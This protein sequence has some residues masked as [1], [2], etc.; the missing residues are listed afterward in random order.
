MQLDFSRVP[1][2]EAQPLHFKQDVFREKLNTDPAIT[3]F[4]DAIHGSNK[5]LDILFRSG[6]NVRSLVRR[7]S[8][9]IDLILH[10]AWHAQPWDDDIVLIA[11]GGYGRS[12]LHPHSDIDILILTE[13]DT[14]KKYDD[15]L[16][17]FVTLLWDIGLA[18]G[19]SVR[20]LKECID[21]ARE[22]ITV[23]TNLLE[24]RTLVGNNDLRL[25]LRK[26]TGPEHIWPMK[27][28]FA[29]KWEAVFWNRNPHSTR[30][31]RLF[32]RTRI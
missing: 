29:A 21:I 11:V 28:F 16:Q 9:F 31:E 26:A 1:E 22:D 2:Y 24:S 19:S 4:K 30:R 20:S 17:S 15:Q 18:V 23:A 5:Y 10:Y 8:D 32:Y 14:G 7:R 12:E 3:V 6:E 13:D 27:A 25:S